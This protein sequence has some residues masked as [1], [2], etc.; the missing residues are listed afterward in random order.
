MKEDRE[1]VRKSG[2]GKSEELKVKIPPPKNVSGTSYAIGG[3]KKL[4]VY[5]VFNSTIQQL[6]SSTIKQLSNSVPSLDT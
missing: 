5:T 1:K 4:T 6:I 2:V 3:D